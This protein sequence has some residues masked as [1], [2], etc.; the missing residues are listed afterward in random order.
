M[1]KEKK[2]VPKKGQK[3]VETDEGGTLKDAPLARRIDITQH[4]VKFV[5]EK[6]TA[7]TKPSK[8]EELSALSADEVEDWVRE[9]CKLKGKVGRNEYDE[10]VE[11]LVD[12][13]RNP[14]KYPRE[15]EDD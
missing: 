8:L 1:A 12:M 14:G 10:Q 15:I 6:M 7:A 5:A 13:I 4:R 11:I 9:K 2:P 3:T